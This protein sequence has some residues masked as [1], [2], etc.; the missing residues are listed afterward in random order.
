MSKNTYESRQNNQTHA[1]EMESE[2]VTMQ[3]TEACCCIIPSI[4][5]SSRGALIWRGVIFIIFGLLMLF[6]PLPTITV[7]VVILGIYAALEGVAMLTGAWVLKRNQ[8]MLLLNGI[9]LLVLGIAAICFPWLMGEY[10]II[11][12]GAWQFISGIQCFF[13]IS[14]SRHRWKT[15]F[16][17]ILAIIAG[18]FFMI[19]PFIGLLAMTWIFAIL[20]F[21]SGAVMF[22]NGVLLRE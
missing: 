1:E 7:V 14:R 18:L 2:D 20:F 12:M 13:F 21:I 22:Y 10:A 16:T 4:L 17:G 3:E 9:V 19:A 8:S 11:F 6:K 15:L 5:Q